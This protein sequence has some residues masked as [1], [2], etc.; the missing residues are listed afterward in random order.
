MNFDTFKRA[1]DSLDGYL[2]IRSIMGGEPTLHP[3]F[4]RF[5]RYLGSKFPPRISENRLIYPQRE[6]IE[7][8]HRIELESVQ[9]INDGVER[10]DVVGAGM[11]SNMGASYKKYY[12]VIGDML[13]F[14]GLN[15]HMN[16]IY[17]QSALITRKDMGIPD[18][19]WR[20]LRDACWLQNEWSAGITPK[21]AFFCEMAG[22]L[23]M[24]FDGPGGWLI[25]P[26]WWKREPKDF[27]EQLRW[28]ELCGFALDTFTRNSAEEI[29][30]VS[31]TMYEMLK[32]VGSP[33]LKSGRVN[34]IKIKNG[35][36]AEES[37]RENRHFS[38][39][40]PYIEHYEDRFN[41]LNSVLF[42][43]EYDL[44][45]IGGN[46]TYNSNDTQ[47]ANKTTLTE[48][49]GFGAALNKVLEAS[50]EWIVARSPNV[51]MVDDY[52][53]RMGK[54]VLN[55]G[56]MHY[57]DLSRSIDT[58]YVKNADKERQGFVAMFSK[59]AI[60]L[61]EFGF[62]RIAHAKAFAEI[63]NMWQP[64]KV[65]EL[66]SKIDEA[67]KPPSLKK[68][69]RYAVWGTGSA[70]SHAVDAIRCA[71]AELAC[72]VDRD[73]SRHGKDFYGVTIQ[74]PEYLSGKS[75]EFDY[76]IAA[77]YTRFIEIRRDAMNMGMTKD[78]ILLMT[79]L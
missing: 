64:N 20:K 2:G 52:C 57:L 36:I 60:S 62:D 45:V 17:H 67:N 53:E 38:A 12:E 51:E 37:K 21:G 3:E 42:S 23:D 59:K 66:S 18:D 30:D 39:A 72:A 7:T 46:E 69:A 70:G 35:E 19:E 40:M 73:S 65:V 8:I 26:G 74:S 11:F 63:V 43:H 54:Y 29:D 61:R 34:V 10:I 76:L 77:N 50:N 24:L 32:T 22:V 78:K 27:G 6:F 55:P 71:G 48:S 68:G 5:I 15:D 75:H 56:T 58:E 16:P 49:A 33:K 28:C 79:N 44:I 13:P 47:F 31:P 9:Y 25:E 41:A 1:V 14:Q 4:E